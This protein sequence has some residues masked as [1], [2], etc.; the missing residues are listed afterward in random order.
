MNNVTWLG[1]PGIKSSGSS[2]VI[3]LLAASE[4]VKLSFYFSRNADTI[5]ELP[6]N[7]ADVLRVET[8]LAIATR[9]N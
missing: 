5:N 3:I 8:R 4:I 1:L 9:L 2:L 7:I 6:I